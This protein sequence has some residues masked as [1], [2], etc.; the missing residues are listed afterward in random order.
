MFAAPGWSAESTSPESESVL[1]SF[2]N[3][4]LTAPGALSQG[5]GAPLEIDIGDKGPLIRN[6]APTIAERRPG[7]PCRTLYTT[8]RA[9]VEDRCDPF[10]ELGANARRRTVSV[11][12][13]LEEPVDIVGAELR[14]ALS[15]PEGAP[16]WSPA[17][18]RMATAADGRPVC[19]AVWTRGDD[20]DL[21]DEDDGLWRIRF[22]SGWRLKPGEQAVIGPAD[23]WIGENSPAEPFRREAR[24]WY[25][26]HGLAAPIE[27]PDWLRR[28]VLYEASAGGHIDSRFSDVG[29]F[30]AFS[31]QLDYLADLGVN[32]IWLNAV[33]MHKT[34]PNPTQGGWNHYDP[35]D[36][37]RVDPILGG[38]QGLRDLAQ[39]A[40]KRGIHLIGEMVPHGGRSRQAEPLETWWTRN[41]NLEP[42]RPWGGFGIDNA[43]PE[44]Q[45]VMR[46][47]IARL[48]KD[49]GIEG[50][51]IDVADGQGFNWGSPRTNHASYSTVGAGVEML[52]ALR[53]GIA[54]GP[55]QRPVLI[56]ESGKDRPEYF[57][58][59][60]A[61]VVGY[62]AAFTRLLEVGLRFDLADA[63][64]IN[65]VITDFFEQERGALP[66]GAL[67][68]RT[69]N[70]HDTVCAAGRPAFRFGTGLARALYGVC[71]SVPGVP[72]MYQEE[73]VGSFEELRRMNWARRR[74]PELAGPDSDY[75]SLAFDPE[76]FSVL[77]FDQGRCAAVCLV[78]LSGNTVRRAAAIPQRLG[79]RDGTPLYDGV[80]GR[81]ARI[82]HGRF[83]WTLDPYAT[84]LFRIGS[85]PEGDLPEPLFQGENP[86]EPSPTTN[87]MLCD[88]RKDG[89]DLRI[90]RLFCRFPLEGSE[91][92]THARNKRTVHLRSDGASVVFQRSGD[93]V[94]VS[95]DIPAASA[96]PL[97][98][99][100]ISHADRWGVMGRTARLED[101]FLRRRFPFPAE[102]NYRWDKYHSWVPDILYHHVAPTGRLWQS[103]VEPL[104]PD[105]PAFA[106][107]DAEGHGFL[108][109]IASSN[110]QNIVL[111]DCGDEAEHAAPLRLEL[112]FYK[113]DTDLHPSVRDFG[114]G[115]L[116]RGES[117]SARDG[118]NLR[119][120]LVI[121]PLR[122]PIRDA[123]TATPLP[124]DTRRPAF[125]H[126]RPI[127]EHGKIIFMPQPG[128]LIWS[129][130]APV[131]GRFHIGL[132]LRSSERGADHGDLC[133]AYRMTL[134]TFEQ[135]LEW[136]QF[137]T[138]PRLGNAW[139]GLALTPPVDLSDT[140]HTIGIET[141]R[142]WCA[143]VR[144]F[145]LQPVE[146]ATPNE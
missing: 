127:S 67:V 2:E 25:A 53:D 33:H 121:Q 141:S 7:E 89:W 126:T 8:E 96:C 128:R 20:F 27:Y 47:A 50:A 10:P 17:T 29:G 18:F 31:H 35:I 81:T 119:V 120:D 144:G 28:G 140:L 73:E 22:H 115:A 85:P 24:K 64:R 122:K 93:T 32:A 68:L 76:V 26:A 19:L 15:V 134:N 57:A 114:I 138:A 75:T 80:S 46:N 142:P 61:A 74:I 40:Q 98:P 48:A 92:T 130:L 77:R 14:F 136:V 71:L 103:V 41:R 113:P 109:T 125:D 131:T 54:E 16:R 42:V 146:S 79:I 99:L 90:G 38:E 52:R 88:L 101:R 117:V 105:Q 1:W 143:V 69:L 37:D 56:P 86:T 6:V 94:R 65:R 82:A 5:A 63:V 118:G 12:N 21:V 13:R 97:P 104:H 60:N 124:P 4:W 3:G 108:I 70:N 102:A 23:I 34:P 112:R 95:C 45:T 59:E 91:W 49:A 110:A 135:P 62:G 145:L 36:F 30:R 116:W 106:C 66:P 111:T 132:T 9:F 51:R 78:N 129:D 72:M 87:R 44:W 123:L 11:I 133:G 55:A 39:E 83:R 107:A 43:S 100:R 137:E 58:V 139:F 84:A